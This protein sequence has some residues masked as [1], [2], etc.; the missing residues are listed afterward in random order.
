LSILYVI[1]DHYIVLSIKLCRCCWVWFS[2]GISCA[3]ASLMT[4]YKNMLCH[5][6]HCNWW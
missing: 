5:T 3:I 1:D 2:F 6:N 4:I